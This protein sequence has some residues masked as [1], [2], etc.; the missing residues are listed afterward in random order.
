MFYVFVCQIDHPHIN[1]TTNLSADKKK[2]AECMRPKCR[3][4]TLCVKK[5]TQVC[6]QRPH[7]LWISGIP[8]YLFPSLFLDAGYFYMGTDLFRCVW[9]N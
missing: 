1:E 8:K 3:T 4:L 6:L 2:V 9:Q 7:L 5:I